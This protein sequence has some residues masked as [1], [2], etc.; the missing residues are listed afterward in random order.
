MD[1][2]N[3]ESSPTSVGVTQALSSSSA[4]VFKVTPKIISK[5]MSFDD[6]KYMVAFLLILMSALMLGYKRVEV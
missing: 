3:T 6:L 5:K 4:K 2:S 1:D